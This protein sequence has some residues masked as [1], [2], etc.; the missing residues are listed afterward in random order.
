M[1]NPNTKIDD[2]GHQTPILGDLHM[3]TYYVY[4]T[5][6]LYHIFIQSLKLYIYIYIGI[7]HMWMCV[8]KNAM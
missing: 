8:C 4:L 7:C 2:L 3:Y 1:E 5:T 6:C